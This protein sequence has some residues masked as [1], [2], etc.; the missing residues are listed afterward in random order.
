MTSSRYSS[1]GAPQSP[2]TTSSD[3]PVKPDAS[4]GSIVPSNEHHAPITELLTA[5]ANLETDAYVRIY[6]GQVAPL[7]GFFIVER[8]ELFGRT[9]EEIQSHFS[10][11]F[12]PRMLCDAHIPVGG[13]FAHCKLTNS[14]GCRVSIYRAITALNLSSPRPLVPENITQ[15][16]VPEIAASQEPAKPVQP[17][18]PEPLAVATGFNISNAEQ[19]LRNYYK[20]DAA[21]VR[22]PDDI[23]FTGPDKFPYVAAQLDSAPPVGEVI[24]EG[25]D[26]RLRNSL[27]QS[28]LNE[29]FG[30]AILGDRGEK[31]LWVYR[32][33]DLLCF[34][35]F[36]SLRPSGEYD[37]NAYPG[38]IDASLPPGFSVRQGRPSEEMLPACARRSIADRIGAE[39][40][41]PVP[42]E[43]YLFEYP[44]V[45]R[46]RRLKLVIPE[47]RDMTTEQR[48][49]ISAA[50]QW[51]LP[52]ALYT[53]SSP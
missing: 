36:G 9:Q 20:K 33:S 10:L 37:P 4:Q 45:D 21:P 8:K 14:A 12:V 34:S 18:L 29:G 46:L 43:F 52:Y 30:L 50:A 2:T 27:V 26:S 16:L 53:S 11:T 40:G 48:R 7:A 25:L 51:C 5:V 31:P 15:I 22:I 13:K 23:K 1:I 42:H 38:T 19:Y 32:F 28:L 39:I 17:P 41:W 3:Q 47:L 6:D 49:A 24:T 44:E 35:I